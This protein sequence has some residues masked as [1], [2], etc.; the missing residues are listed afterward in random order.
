MRRLDVI[1]LWIAGLTLTQL[2]AGTAY[3]T[4]V[5]AQRIPTP[6]QNADAIRREQQQIDHLAQ[7]DTELFKLEALHLDTRLAVLE[8]GAARLGK[9]ELLCYGLVITMIGNLLGT[10]IQIRGQRA[11]RSWEATRSTADRSDE[12]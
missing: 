6:T 8:E 9:I 1:R 3:I 2:L 11:R 12:G 10:V 4:T 5:Y 7:I